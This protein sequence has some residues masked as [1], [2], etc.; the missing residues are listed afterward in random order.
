MEVVQDRG[1]TDTHELQGCGPG[2]LSPPAQILPRLR[3]QS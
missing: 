2:G 3:R 1:I